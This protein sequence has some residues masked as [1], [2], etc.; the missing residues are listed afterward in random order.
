M[1]RCFFILKE[2]TLNEVQDTCFLYKYQA[3]KSA[4]DQYTQPIRN[5]HWSVH[6]KRKKKKRSLISNQ[7]GMTIDQYT[8]YIFMYALM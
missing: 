7:L 8:Q 5:D 1:E 4:I 2:S 3:Q 6:S